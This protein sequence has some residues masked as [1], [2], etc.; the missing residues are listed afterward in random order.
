[1]YM[2][3]EYAQECNS[4]LKW[5]I[6]NRLSTEKWKK[7]VALS[8]L[9]ERRDITYTISKMWW[10][11]ACDDDGVVMW[12]NNGRKQRWEVKEKTTNECSW[13]KVYL[14]SVDVRKMGA[15]TAMAETKL[16]D[17]GS[18]KNKLRSGRCNHVCEVQIKNERK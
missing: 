12:S 10:K 16:N 7:K 13:R 11:D 4:V 6:G 5:R 2:R 8:S 3:S 17:G 15:P 9:R 14:T 18:E 1:M